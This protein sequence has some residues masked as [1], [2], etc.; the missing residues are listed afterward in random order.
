MFSVRQ[1]S[2]NSEK[3]LFISERGKIVLNDLQGTTFV[4]FYR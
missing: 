2:S 1:I 3:N 4:F